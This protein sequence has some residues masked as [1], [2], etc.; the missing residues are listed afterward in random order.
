MNADAVNPRASAA[1]DAAAGR[2]E[3]RRAALREACRPR[4][5][6]PRPRAVHTAGWVLTG[7]GLAGA[8]GSVVAFVIA[9]VALR[10]NQPAAGE[11]LVA[12]GV[13]LAVG[14]FWARVWHG[15]RTLPDWQVMPE[16]PTR[17][18]AFAAGGSAA[19]A[20]LA[21]C[22]GGLVVFAVC[23]RVLFGGL[24]DALGLTG[25]GKPA[26]V[27]A[28]LGTGLY[29][30]LLWYLFEGL[31]ELREPARLGLLAVLGV[32]VGAAVAAGAFCVAGVFGPGIAWLAGGLGV[33]AA[34]GL[35]LGWRCAGADVTERFFRVNEP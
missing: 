1:E 28:G 21:A 6:Y 24:V 34:A 33:A 7:I 2:A 35:V 29:F 5:E 4:F 8:V 11:G 23:S 13:G 9:F 26:F 16:L 22:A 10:S 3:E 14:L 15:F 19:S 27:L 32:T 31:M 17:T 20:C 18:K 30:V 25:V 12:A